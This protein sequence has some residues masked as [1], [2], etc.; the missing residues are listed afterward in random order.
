MMFVFL[1][2]YNANVF[3]N[4]DVSSVVLRHRLAVFR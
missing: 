3:D 2:L 1:C 4:E